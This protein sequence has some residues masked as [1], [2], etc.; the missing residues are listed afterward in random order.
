[1]ARSAG[2]VFLSYRRE[3]SRHLAGRLADRIKAQ[4]SHVQVF[5]DVD[6]VTPGD[7]FGEAISHAV[8]SC[9]VLIALIGPRWVTVAD[10]QGRRRLDNTHD[11]VRQEIGVALARGIRVI[12]VLVDEAA[13]PTVADLPVDLAGL[14]RRNAVR[15]DHDT[16]S[17]DIHRLLD[18]IGQTLQGAPKLTDTGPGRRS[19]DLPPKPP[20]RQVS[21]DSG[22]GLSP[23]RVVPLHRTALRIG[24]WTITFPLALFSA[25]SLGLTL[26]GKVPSIAGSLVLSV[27]LFG[28]IAGLLVW[29]HKETTA[30][31]SLILV[32]AA[33]KG[34]RESVDLRAGLSH[35]TV[36]TLHIILGTVT[37]AFTLLALFT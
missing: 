37:L 10:T 23:Q 35:T 4:F 22:V 29:I 16:F 18:A 19:Y 8:S 34:E 36:R 6:I 1:V 32:A 24:L 3:E 2:R 25:V 21:V 30:Q 17:T 26:G 27:F 14:A 31:R 12:P 28:I 9:D 13:M 11:W 15:I 5:M 20:R 33:A 7:D